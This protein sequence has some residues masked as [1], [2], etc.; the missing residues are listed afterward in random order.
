MNAYHIGG[1]TKPERDILDYL[2]INK[3]APVGDIASFIAKEHAEAAELLE[4]LYSMRMVRRA[5][6]GGNDRYQS[7]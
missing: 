2:R 3:V 4:G 7:V 1:I 5:P 6:S